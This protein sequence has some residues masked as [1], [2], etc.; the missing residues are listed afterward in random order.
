M[1]NHVS[2][3]LLFW[4]TAVR[5][6]PVGRLREKI[7]KERSV[8]IFSVLYRKSYFLCTLK[9]NEIWNGYSDPGRGM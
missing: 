9:K 8:I 5:L 4:K 3:F 1:I 2:V 6:K 7:I